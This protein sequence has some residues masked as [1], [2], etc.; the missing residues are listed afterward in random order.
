MNFNPEKFPFDF[1]KHRNKF[2]L[3][4][5]ILIIAGTISLFV[6]GLNLGIDFESGTRIDLETGKS[7]TNEDVYNE[8]EEIGYTPDEVTLAGNNNEI[9]TAHFIGVLEQEEIAEVK[10]HFIEKYDYEPNVSTVSPQVG[11]ELARNAFISV[12]IASVG[13]IIYVAFR[14][15]WLQGLA[16][17]LAMMH[18][19]FFI[20]ALFSILQIEVNITFIAAV[21]TIVGYSVND[22][23][24]TFDR[25]RE[26]MRNE[27]DGVKDFTNVARIVNISLVQTLARSINTVLTVV[28]AALALMIFGSESIR[29]FSVA[30]VIGL[31]SG[32]Y[33]SL[34]IAS[35]V[36]AV[37]KGKELK[38]PKKI[39]EE[40]EDEFDEFEEDYIK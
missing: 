21:L 24:V 14:F 20:I 28:F 8:F 40:T 29:T 34:F 16:A 33:S 25:I 35:Q 2:F 19:A 15:E 36:W 22:T 5:L 30:L 38:R 26:N 11:R 4:T 3:L 18:D 31:I 10:S 27:K 9:G 37:W 17:I 1:V 13:I 39:K 6:N 32:T 23:I 7:L 12:A